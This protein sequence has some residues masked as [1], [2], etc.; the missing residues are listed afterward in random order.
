VVA[1][2]AVS[3]SAGCA[4]GGPRGPLP[5]GVL[6][7]GCG[8]ARGLTPLYFLPFAPG[9][10]FELT[11]GNCG[12]VSHG[13]RFS[14]S[15]D[16]RM[17]VGTPVLAARDGIV[18]TVRDDSPDG[19]RRVGDENLVFIW[20]EGGQISRYIHLKQHGVRVWVGQRVSAGDT[21]ALS[22]NSGQSAFPH[23]HFDVADRCRGGCRTTPAAFLNADPP[24]PTARRP[25]RALDR[26]PAAS[27]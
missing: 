6:V 10:S 21:I 25:V 8:P 22:G 14:Y 15:F 26:E 7:G 12:D 19:T 4:T 5:P 16:F 11:Q 27:E 24:I 9:E 17:P 18:R 3:L 13:G 20:H 1:V 23:L 2:L